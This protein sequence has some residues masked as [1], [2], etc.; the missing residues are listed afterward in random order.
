MARPAMALALGALGRESELGQRVG[1]ILRFGEWMRPAQARVVMGVAML[2]LLGGATELARCPQIVG[3]S[4]ADTGGSQVAARVAP[5][6][7]ENGF[8]YQAVV[9]R[10][11]RAKASAATNR[12]ARTRSIRT[13]V[14]MP[15]DG[16]QR[17]SSRNVTQGQWLVVTSWSGTNGSRVVLTTMTVP[18]A[19]ESA[20]SDATGQ[21]TAGDAQDAAQQVPR[22]A[23]VPVR[24]GWL[25]F[26][27]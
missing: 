19:L 24:G 1:R 9:F 11:D 21:A 2:G 25:V 3:F 10:P 4:A 15:S 23:A 8:G 13:E 26:Q 5:A 14:A 20:P 7:A 17:S 16:E 12:T 6:R 22:Y 18:D 27:L